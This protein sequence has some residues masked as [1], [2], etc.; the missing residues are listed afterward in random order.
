MVRNKIY[1]TNSQSSVR[2][3]DAFSKLFLS[4]NIKTKTKIRLQKHYRAL[5]TLLFTKNRHLSSIENFCTSILY[6]S[7]YLRSFIFYHEI[8]YVSFSCNIS[9]LSR[10]R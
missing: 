9:D 7:N 10:R 8:S 4:S 1:N 6:V 3:P 5:S 2:A